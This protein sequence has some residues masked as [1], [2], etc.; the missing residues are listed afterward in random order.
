MDGADYRNFSYNNSLQSVWYKPFSSNQQKS[1]TCE[2]THSSA[3]SI[4]NVLCLA[5]RSRVT[6]GGLTETLVPYNKTCRFTGNITIS[7]D[8][9][10]ICCPGGPSI[11][12]AL[13]EPMK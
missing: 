5:M 9:T 4:M 7:A 2:Y 1:E 13:S 6:E 12:T 10:P 8:L 3:F 11:T